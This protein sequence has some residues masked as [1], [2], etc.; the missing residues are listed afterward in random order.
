[1][2]AWQETWKPWVLFSSNEQQQDIM[3]QAGVMEKGGGWRIER[4][5]AADERGSR[6]VTC[7]N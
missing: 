7:S 2:L 4:V 6:E 3:C 5:V 1:M